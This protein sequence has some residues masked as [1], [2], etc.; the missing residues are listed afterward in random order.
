MALPDDLLPGAPSGADG[1]WTKGDLLRAQRVKLE[2]FSRF[3]VL[4]AA[5]DRHLV[6]FF[7]GFLTEESG[8]GER[9]GVRLTTIEEREASQRAYVAELDALLASGEIPTM[10]SGEMVAPVIQCLE[11]DQPGWFPLNVPNEGQVADLPDGATV[12]SIC[13]VDGKGVRGRDEVR[14]PATVA[15]LLRRVA[16]AQEVT[17]DAAVRGDR[18]RVF[19]A[20]LLDPLAGRLDYERLGAMTDEMLAATCRWLPQFDGLGAVAR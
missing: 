18:D 16:A 7:S 19:E 10:P 15:E 6:E 8:W 14:L 2:L 13:V 20:M 9:W 5:G 12:E 17:V 3:G 1:R 4:P 11:L